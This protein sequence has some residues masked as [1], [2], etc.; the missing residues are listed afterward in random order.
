[1]LDSDILI[2]PFPLKIELG[3][4]EVKFRVAAPRTILL[5]SYYITWAKTGDAFIP[6]YAPLKRTE[7]RMRS[8]FV[9]RQVLFEEIGFIPL[10]GTSFPLYVF[11]NNPPYDELNVTLSILYG[12]T[13]AILNTTT[14]TYGRGEFQVQYFLH[15]LII[16]E[17]LY[18]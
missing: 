11:T 15:M 14:L 1:V 2:T 4:T 17:K 9:K 5:K 16:K 6:S 7:I 10:G 12:N 13:D 18:Y 3:A 8:G